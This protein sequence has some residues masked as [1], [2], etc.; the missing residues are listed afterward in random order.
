[1]ECC[2][3]K[4]SGTTSYDFTSA[5]SQAYGGNMIQKGNKYCIYSGDLNQDGNVNGLDIAI[6]DNQAFN[7]L[8]GYVSG[9]VN[10]DMIVDAADLSIVDNNAFNFISKVTPDLNLK[11]EIP[12]RDRNQRKM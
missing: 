5:A 7:F 2:F 11:F 9:D 1:M 4:I 3:F 8:T 12:L 10:G 6:A